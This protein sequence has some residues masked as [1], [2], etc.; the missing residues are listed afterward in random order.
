M[1]NACV[2]KF[3]VIDTM[4]IFFWKLNAAMEAKGKRMRDARRSRTDIFGEGGAACRYRSSRSRLPIIATTS[5]TEV[6][7][8]RKPQIPKSQ[9][10][11]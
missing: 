3:D 11:N 5:F 4:Q 2:R 9:A 6:P 10:K 8:L 7:P 1:L